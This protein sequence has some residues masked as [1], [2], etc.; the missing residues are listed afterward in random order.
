MRTSSVLPGVLLLL[1]VIAASAAGGESGFPLSV[2]GQSL[3]LDRDSRRSDVA[4]ALRRVWPQEQPSVLTPTRIQYD[5][6]AVPGQGPVSLA[7]DFDAKGLF[8]GAIIDAMAKEQNPV[9]AQLAAWLTAKAGTG[10]RSKGDRLWTHGG[11]RFRLTEVK[12]AGEESAYR[13]CI[14]R[15]TR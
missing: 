9:A 13:M 14:D 8:T 15:Q 3:T 1:L 4:A 11:F 2:G 5:V 6:I 7:F 10:L 12:T